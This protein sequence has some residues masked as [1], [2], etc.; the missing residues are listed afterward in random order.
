MPNPT[1]PLAADQD[2]SKFSV[3]QEDPALRTEIEGGYVV[4]R[5]KHTRTPRKTFTTGFAYL[6]NTDR[7][8]LQTFWN[9]VSGGTL[10]IDWTN[11]QDLAVYQVRF[12]GGPLK[13]TYVGRLGNQRWD[14]AITLEQV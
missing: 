5:K 10:I 13:F 14:V 12:K 4:T 1:F 8:T 11:P 9:T 3:E 2:S 6:N 7:A